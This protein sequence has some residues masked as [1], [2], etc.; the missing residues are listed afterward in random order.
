L[1]WKK[2]KDPEKP[3]MKIPYYHH[4]HHHHVTGIDE[5][6]SIIQEI[7]NHNARSD[8]AGSWRILGFWFLQS[9]FAIWD[10]KLMT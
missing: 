8:S 3:H 5:I 7:R 10:T 4:H 2:K 6:E 9:V 1:K